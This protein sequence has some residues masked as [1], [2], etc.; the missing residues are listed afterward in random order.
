MLEEVVYVSYD[1]DKLTELVLYV[2]ERTQG[3]WTAGATKLNKYLHFAD[4][5][6]VRRLGH[7]ITGAEYQELPHGPAPRRLTPVR[8]R[9]VRSGAARLEKRADAF[10]YVDDVLVPQRPARTELFSV[11]ELELVD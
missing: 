10:G 8:E 7:A 9:R 11:D 1:E 6:A 4:F 2:A 3:N 5:A